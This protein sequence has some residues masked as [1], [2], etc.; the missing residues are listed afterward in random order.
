M[1]I[2]VIL[3][4]ICLALSPCINANETIKPER[5]MVT[6]E[7]Y[8]IPNAETTTIKLTKQ[9]LEEIEHLFNELQD[10]LDTSE[11]SGETLELFYEA[12]VQLDT[13]GLFGK[14]KRQEIVEAMI[15]KFQ[16]PTR[17]SIPK[18]SFIKNNPFS[19]SNQNSLCFIIGRTT[20]TWFYGVWSLALL[21]M[22]IRLGIGSTLRMILEALILASNRCIPISLIGLIDYYYA[23]GWV[24]TIGL[25]GIANWNGT[26]TGMVYGFIGLH[27]T[28]PPCQPHADSF[29]LGYAMNANIEYL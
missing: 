24:K 1:T 23:E 8:G 11:T 13:Y 12:A 27:I 18:N 5:F 15:E 17:A 3:L 7:F 21:A 29:Y 28:F 22:L 2:S 6:T 16:K 14:A 10:K 19:D 26:L 4:F 20:N 9:Q 25:H